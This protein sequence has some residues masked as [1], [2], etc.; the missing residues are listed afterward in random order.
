MKKV[1]FFKKNYNLFINSFKSIDHKIFFI[2]LSDL[3][4]Y[5]LTP[6]I[7]LGAANILENKAKSINIPLDL[8]QLEVAGL[9][10]FASQISSFYYTLITVLIVLLLLVIINWT[11]FKGFAWGLVVKRKFT[12][13]FFLR[14]F[15]LN[16][17]ILGSLTLIIFLTAIV[18][19]DAFLAIFM[20]ILFLIYSYFGNI[21]Y[22]KFTK[23]PTYKTVK[24]AIKLSIKKIHHFI[25]MFLIIIVIFTIIY[26]LLLFATY[27]PYGIGM[28]IMI[29]MLLL[30]AAWARYYI[31]KVVNIF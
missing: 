26:N 13:K 9:E 8:S 5:V 12:I 17:I 14:F 3:I 1:G 2:I 25:F 31:V 18:Y 30:F 11:I 29:L 20:F 21:I 16:L 24:E 15:I 10:S 27:L 4:F 28:S 7:G 23:T 22:A 6:I 19:Q